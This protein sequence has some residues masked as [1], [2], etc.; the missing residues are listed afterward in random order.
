M[1]ISYVCMD[2]G[3]YIYTCAPIGTGE[4]PTGRIEYTHTYRRTYLSQRDSQDGAARVVGLGVKGA[5]SEV[6]HEGPRLPVGQRT[7]AGDAGDLFCGNGGVEV[8]QHGKKHNT[9]H[10][11]RLH[12]WIQK[13][14]FFLNSCLYIHAPAPGPRRRSRSS[15]SSARPLPAARGPP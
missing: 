4:G 5:G 10:I 8:N 13:P 6:Q 9:S 14:Y 2:V 11:M 1:R 12:K 7:S 15:R 3:Q